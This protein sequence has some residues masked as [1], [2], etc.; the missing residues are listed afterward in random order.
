MIRYRQKQK[1]RKNMATAIFVFAI[2]AIAGV[3]YLI[4]IRNS[5]TVTTDTSSETEAADSNTLPEGSETPDTP[6]RQ[7]IVCLDPGHGGKDAGA[8]YKNITESE[9]N[10][11]VA[12][13]VRNML[14]K[15]GYKVYMSR[16]DDSFVYKRPRARY[17]NSVNATIMVAIHHNSYDTDTSVDYSTA[18]YYK[19]SDQALA[20]AVLD[21]VSERLDT[22]NQGIAK[23]DDSLLYIATMPAMLSE[24][25][26]VTSSSEYYQIIKVSSPRLTAE[27]EGIFN[28]IKNY[29]ANPNVSSSTISADSLIIDRPD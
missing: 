4:S 24:A 20:T 22:Q 18:L 6:T 8:I 10:L 27:A 9:L 19:D 12:L 15:D 21:A 17:C 11:N 2:F 26:F 16:D 25:F 14:E 3:S 13:Q 7:E 23:F 5:K 28:G 1:R 29:F